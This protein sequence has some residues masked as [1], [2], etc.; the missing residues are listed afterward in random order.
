MLSVL[1]RGIGA[2]VVAY[3]LSGDPLATERAE[4]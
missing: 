4:E 3:G 2:L 1:L